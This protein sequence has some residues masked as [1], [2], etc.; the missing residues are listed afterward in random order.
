MATF[1]NQAQLSY[2]GIITNSNIATGQIIEVLSVT[3]LRFLTL[4][5]EEMTLLTLS[6]S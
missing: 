4:I 6:I 2:N 1:T 5:P 3:K